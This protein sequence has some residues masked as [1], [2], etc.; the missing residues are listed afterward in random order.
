[1]SYRMK[2]QE[3]LKWKFNSP[4]ILSAINVFYNGPIAQAIIGEQ[5]QMVQDVLDVEP[6]NISELVQISK[7]ITVPAD[8]PNAADTG[9][10]PKATEDKNE[11]GIVPDDGGRNARRYRGTTRPPEIWP[12]IW[13]MM[14]PK[15]K[16][17]AR[18]EWE[19]TVKKH[20]LNWWGEPLDPSSGP[21]ALAHPTTPGSPHAQLSNRRAP[22]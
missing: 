11:D 13:T 10:H 6:K 5:I 1:M 9:D 18:A 14:T 17:E 16:L 3:N 22:K 19:S 8:H 2:K 20:N 21:A 12:E 15:Q 7:Y 4:K